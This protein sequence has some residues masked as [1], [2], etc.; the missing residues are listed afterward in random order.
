MI[1]DGYPLGITGKEPVHSISVN[2][3]LAGA[4]VSRLCFEHFGEQNACSNRRRFPYVF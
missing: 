1:S 3:M 2:R 4:D